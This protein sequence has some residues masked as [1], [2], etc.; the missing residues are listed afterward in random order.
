[1]ASNCLENRSLS[2]FS[3]CGAQFNPE[4]HVAEAL[5]VLQTLQS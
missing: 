2:L 5:Q 4:Q 3:M 1:M